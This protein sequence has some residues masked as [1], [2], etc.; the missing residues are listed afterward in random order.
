MLRQWSAACIHTMKDIWYILQLES[1]AL[2]QISILFNKLTKPFPFEKCKEKDAGLS[3]EY[4][5]V[6]TK[7]IQICVCNVTKWGKLLRGVNIFVL[8]VSDRARQQKVNFLMCDLLTGL[9][10]SILLLGLFCREKG[11]VVVMQYATSKIYKTVNTAASG[12][13]CQ[14]P[15]TRLWA[16][17]ASRR[18][19]DPLGMWLWAPPRP[20]MT[21]TGQVEVTRTPSL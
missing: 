19:C 16:Q 11:Q 2:M 21:N 3:P 12:L 5:A 1:L 10:A 15:G 4:A 13:P 7:H 20:A 14:R 18:A 9:P 17:S 8:T 6:S